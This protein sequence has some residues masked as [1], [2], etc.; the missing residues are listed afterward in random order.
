[1]DRPHIKPGCLSMSVAALL[2][3]LC[4]GCVDQG[5]DRKTKPTKPKKQIAATS[6]EDLAY[7][8]FQNRDKLRAEKLRAL[9]GQGHKYDAKRMALIEQAGADASRESWK[10]VT[11]AIAKKMNAA[12]QTDEAAFDSVLEELARGSEKAS[13]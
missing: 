5:T 12:S 4:F 1:M 6:I 11:E 9:K 13:Q 3:A 10:P 8:S 2:L 7:Q